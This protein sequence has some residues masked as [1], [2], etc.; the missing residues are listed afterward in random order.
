MLAPDEQFASDHE[1]DYNPDWDHPG[2]DPAL[3]EKIQM[4]ENLISHLE[5]AAQDRHARGVNRPDVIPESVAKHND[6]LDKIKS[7]YPIDTAT[8]ERVQGAVET[9]ET[10]IQ[11]L[12]QRQQQRGDQPGQSGRK[13]GTSDVAHK[14]LANQEEQAILELQDVLAEMKDLLA[15]SDPRYRPRN[16]FNGD[17]DNKGNPRGENPRSSFKESEDEK[18]S[19]HSFKESPPAAPRKSTIL[20]VP[21]NGGPAE[22]RKSYFQNRNDTDALKNESNRTGASILV[23]PPKPDA[24]EMRKSQ[25]RYDRPEEPSSKKSILRPRTTFEDE[26]PPKSKI[27]ESLLIPPSKGNPSGRKS[28]WN[29]KEWNDP[30]QDQPQA[31]AP[32]ESA[33]TAFQRK[34]VWDV[35]KRRGA[36]DPGAP[37]EEDEDD[38]S[39][40]Q[41][42]RKEDPMKPTRPR[43]GSFGAQNPNP[44][45]SQPS[46]KN[47]NQPSFRNESQQAKNPEQ[48]SSNT[49]TDDEEIPEA[50]EFI[51]KVI[52]SQC[53]GAIT[54][55]KTI[56]EK[57]LAVGYSSG[58]VGFFSLDDDFKLLSKSKE[59]QSSISAMECAE[60]DLNLNYP[61]PQ[62]HIAQ[63]RLRSVLFTGGN[64]KDKTIVIWDLRTFQPLQRMTGH[65]H[66]ITSIVDLQDRATVATGGMDSKIAFWDLRPNE[67][68]CIQV[69]EDLSFP[70]IV[71]EFDRDDG[72]LTAGTLDGQIG[73]YQVY[74]ED[75]LY[76]GCA[77]MRILALESHVLDILRSSCLPHSILTLESDF[78]IREYDSMTG[79]LNRVVRSHDP[80]IDIFIVEASSGKSAM[81]YAIDTHS[82]LHRIAN[83]AAIPPG[84][85][86]VLPKKSDFS[87][88][89]SG[90]STPKNEN[91]L[92]AAR[93][94]SGIKR[95]IGYNPKSQ[96]F[97]KDYDLILLTADQA[98]QSLL[99]NKLNTD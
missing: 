7:S 58:E 62:P 30:K 63:T 31:M 15:E 20:V 85:T 64:E 33:A 60:I 74:L 67:P 80:L 35:N 99:I 49:V 79:K 19:R 10:E 89:G 13:P 77:L 17:T 82:N 54:V 26:N 32:R 42:P 4:L 2:E 46:F 68:E 21:P 34:S 91:P 47:D 84:G 92:H 23:I 14:K 22:E 72:V 53:H 61:P 12:L 98:N 69:I 37:E 45:K 44:F 18:R 55:I 56:D 43:N 11:G 94:E 25:I 95:F 52:L 59:H 71:M 57:I 90:R 65:Q 88:L 83:W 50:G 16:D 76:V 6:A 51:G 5:R 78:T 36:D 87:T 48:F 70:I 3:P 39:I 73:L 40:S 8:D 97:I 1:D 93:A 66:M 75:G 28:I 9:F 81:I 27:A 41:T 96:I 29:S 24:Q 38:D 86:L